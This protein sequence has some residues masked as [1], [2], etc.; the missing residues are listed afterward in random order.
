MKKKNYKWFWVLGVVV[1]ISIVYI[2]DVGEIK[3]SISEEIKQIQENANIKEMTGGIMDYECP[4]EIIPETFYMDNRFLS[5]ITNGTETYTNYPERVIYLDG[6]YWKDGVKSDTSY[7]EGT[8][9]YFNCHKGQYEGENINYIYCENLSYS[10]YTTPISEKGI[11][12]ETE[13][14]SYSIDLIMEEESVRNIKTFSRGNVPFSTNRVI[15]AK[16]KKL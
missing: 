3:T 7:W 14:F 13:T 15:S 16:C 6:F 5:V 10:K 1:L 8:N 4:K 9:R 2:Y 12:G 11:I